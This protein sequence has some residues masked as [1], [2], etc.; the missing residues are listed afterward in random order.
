M[1]PKWSGLAWDAPVGESAVGV[2]DG[3]GNTIAL[4]CKKAIACG[5]FH[6]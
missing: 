2:G 6:Q 5:E 3:G 4:H 1:T